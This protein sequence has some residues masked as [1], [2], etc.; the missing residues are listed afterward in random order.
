MENVIIID[1][2]LITGKK[3]LHTV[4]RNAIGCDNYIGNNLDALYDA[5]S[6]T[7]VPAVFRFVDFANAYKVL[8]AYCDSLLK[9]LMDACDSN[10]K[11]DIKIVY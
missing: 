7:A 6:S 9:T 11:I 3:Q 5:L 8:G 4:M 10:P 1:C 2:G